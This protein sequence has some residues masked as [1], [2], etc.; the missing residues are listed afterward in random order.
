MKKANQTPKKHKAR[1]ILIVTAAILLILILIIGLVI[2]AFVSSESGRKT[3]LTKI[4][5]SVDGTTDFASLSMG[6]FSG[7]K[8]TNLSF[9]DEAG[10]TSIRIKKIRTKPHYASILAGNLSFGKTI[11]DEPRISINL[12]EQDTAASLEKTQATQQTTQPPKLPISRI[13]LRVSDGSLRIT[14]PKENTVELKQINSSLNLKPPP[15][16]TEFD[17]TA[18]L[19]NQTSQ[20]P[21]KANGTIKPK[22]TKDGLSLAGTTA[23]LDIEVND[24]RLESLESFFA[25][26]GVDLKSKGKASGKITGA[27]KN[28]RLQQLN[29]NIHGQNIE[30]TGQPLK[31]DTFKTSTLSVTSAIQRREGFINIANLDINADWLRAKASG[32]LPMT[33]ES[34]ADFIK[35]K[36]Q[37][38]LKA[39]VTCNV[40]KLAS[41]MPRT[42]GI[43]PDTTLTSGTLTANIEKTDQPALIAQARLDNLSGLVSNKPVRLSQPVVTQTRITSDQ[44]KIR[45]EKLNLSSS[46]ADV[47]CSGTSESLE[48][49]TNLNLANLQAELG[50]FLNLAGYQLVGTVESNGKLTADGKKYQ[51]N[52]SSTARNL[53]VTSPGKVSVAEP[54]ATAN[55]TLDIE[56]EASLLTIKSLQ[57]NA[58]FGRVDIRNSTIPLKKDSPDKLSLNVAAKSLNLARVM[59][60]AGLFSPV[61]RDIKLAGLADSELL[62]RPDKQGLTIR[63]DSTKISNFE[64]A[65]KDKQPFKQNQVSIKLDSRVEP[66]KLSA[67]GSLTSPEISISFDVDKTVEKENTKLKGNAELDYEWKH[68]SRLLSAFM[69]DELSI[70]GKNKTAVEFTSTYPSDKPHKLLANLATEP[71]KVAFDKARYRGFTATQPS[72]IQVKFDNGLLDIPEF[73]MKVNDGT[74]AFAGQADFKKP[75]AVLRTP[76]QMNI[77]Q[78]V[79]IDER[80]SSK[81]LQFINPI[82]KDV[83]R[84]SGTANF[85]CRTLAIP[86]KGASKKD[87]EL[88]GTFSVSNLRMISPILNLIQRIKAAAPQDSVM[89]LRP[90]QIYAKEGRIWY[91]NMQLDVGNNPF[92][93][94]GRIN[95]MTKSIHGTSVKTPYTTG[96]TVKVGEENTPGRISIPFK[97]TYDKPELDTGK[98]IEQNLQNI[99]QD[100]IK[101]GEIDVESLKDILDQL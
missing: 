85:S 90:T 68:I 18:Q 98:L 10:R 47:D 33:F 24:L 53:S 1:K 14:D 7:V 46:F 5:E 97:G 79:K 15:K 21:I 93:F 76:K 81:L 88:D 99:I 8:L 58:A 19:T 92:N 83:D 6:W 27:I 49:T 43:K 75:A 51:L 42:L 34:L 31:G 74:F 11:I 59:P 86:L 45:F 52:G 25:L 39:E 29:A 95:L 38:S 82:F 17:L 69:P 13:D 63:T 94:V 55:Y 22:I 77:L 54:A 84:I 100:T 50:Q 44:K 65:Y 36:S 41:Q 37:Q 28:G 9:D 64:F 12:K 96:R 73:S 71:I 20:S 72:Q 61:V 62:I 78:N 3:I 16:L 70:E 67:K 89:Q 40:A 60:I 91:D 57:T 80:V 30:I 32:D 26:A 66:E 35:T 2:P 87:F 23:D 101:D 56:P 48:Y 4:N